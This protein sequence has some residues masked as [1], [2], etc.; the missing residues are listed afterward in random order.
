LVI[1]PD[2]GSGAPKTSVKAQ[3]DID[4]HFKSVLTIKEYSNGA[5]AG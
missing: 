1:E 4:G 5:S 2:S 3:H